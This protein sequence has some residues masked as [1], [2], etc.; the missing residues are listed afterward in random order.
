MSTTKLSP[1]ERAR[2]Y[3]QKCSG[4]ISGQRGHDVTFGIA[5]KL[6]QGFALSIED[7]LALMREWNALCQPRWKEKQLRHKVRDAAKRARGQRGFLL[8]PGEKAQKPRRRSR[9]EIDA[10]RAEM[11][12][13]RLEAR[14]ASSLAYILKE[15]RCT[16]DDFMRESPFRLWGHTEPETG[17]LLQLHRPEDVIWIGNQFSSGKPEHA[18]HFRTVEQWLTQPPP[19]HWELTCP[20]TFKPGSFSRCDENVLEKRFLVMESD[21]LNRDQICSV[22]QWCRKFMRL[23]AIVNTAGKSLHGWFDKPS[24][25]TVEELRSILPGLQ[26]DKSLLALSQPCRIPGAWR[27]DKKARQRLVYLDLE[28]KQ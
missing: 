16:P 10:E 7:T 9:A 14:A 11:H 20:A 6:Y 18:I 24:P 17:L 27:A 2:L 3:V 23:R 13:R 25:E 12:C 15:N 1:L 4:A 26:C 19:E 5:C 8:G 22:F 28:G 21:D